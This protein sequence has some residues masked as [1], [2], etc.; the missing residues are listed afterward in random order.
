M[1]LQRVS[2]LQRSQVICR[3]CKADDRPFPINN[4]AWV[5]FYFGIRKHSESMAIFVVEVKKLSKHKSEKLLHVKS[6]GTT[7]V[8]SWNPS[9]QHVTDVAVNITRQSADERMLPAI[10]MEGK[11]TVL[12]F[13]KAKSDPSSKPLHHFSNRRTLK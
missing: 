6:T 5:Q 2:W 3:H 9:S 1:D 7:P 10:I 13:A 12:K 11:C 4:S 8:T